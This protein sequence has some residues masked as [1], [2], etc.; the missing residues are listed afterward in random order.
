M[1]GRSKITASARPLSI[2]SMAPARE[3]ADTTRMSCLWASSK[4]LVPL[5]TATRRDCSCVGSVMAASVAP[6]RNRVKAD[7]RL[8]VSEDTAIREM[9]IQIAVSP[10]PMR[11]TGALSP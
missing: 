7:A 11:V 6:V 8:A 1:A 10:R 3:S 4:A 5:T 2:S 9:V